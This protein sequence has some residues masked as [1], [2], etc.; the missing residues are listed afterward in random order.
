MIIRIVVNIILTK[1][2]TSYSSLPLDLGLT[3]PLSWLTDE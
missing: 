2:L 1:M 3:W